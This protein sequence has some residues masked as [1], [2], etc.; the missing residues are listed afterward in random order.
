MVHDRRILLFITLLCSV[1]H[2]T[3]FSEG[4]VASTY[5]VSPNPAIYQNKTCHTFSYYLT[6]VTKYFTWSTTLLFLPGTHNIIFTAGKMVVIKDVG[7]VNFVGVKLHSNDNVSINCNRNIYAGITFTNITTVNIVNLTISNCGA[8]VSEFEGCTTRYDFVCIAALVA[9]NVGSFLVQ[10]TVVENSTKIGIFGYIVAHLSITKSKFVGNSL[11]EK[12]RGVTTSHCN[13]VISFTRFFTSGHGFEVE[14][15]TVSVVNSW[16]VGNYDGINVKNS[17]ASFRGL[18]MLGPEYDDRDMFAS[19]IR[20]TNST[21]AVYGSSFSGYAACITASTCITNVSLC[22][23]ENNSD[24]LVTYVGSQTRVT[25]SIFVQNSGFSQFHQDSSAI[26]KNTTYYNNRRSCIFAYNSTIEFNGQSLFQNCMSVGFGGA[27]YLISSIMLLTAPANVSFVN[28]TAY[29]GGGAIY[30]QSPFIRSFEQCF[31]QIIDEHGT[32]NNPGVRLYFEGNKAWKVGSVL[33]G[34]I[35]SCHLDYYKVDDHPLTIFAAISTID[36]NIS[37]IASDAFTMC[38]CKDNTASPDCNLNQSYSG[39]PGQTISIVGLDLYGSISPSMV[40]SYTV[41]FDSSAAMLLSLQ[42]N[43][44]ACY[45]YVVQSNLDDKTLCMLT[46]SAISQSKILQPLCIHFKVFECP[47]G[48]VLNDTS[49]TC[50]CNQ[51]LLGANLSCSIN[52]LTVLKSGRQWVGSISNIL[53]AYDSCPYDYCIPSPISMSLNAPDDQC[54]YYRG[55]ILCGY[56]L[57]GL[58]AMFGSSRCSKCSNYYTSF[59]SRRL[60]CWEWH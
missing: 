23:F 34:N 31:L 32:L 21:L 41:D 18:I 49:K 6:A 58:S 50:S 42:C 48:F 47:L 24:V 45:D 51:F 20:C 27:I 9:S 44:N 57:E 25:D 46:Q 1:G 2:Q 19:G 16:V 13:L 4:Q 59:I 8:Q 39:Y 12:C 43:Q 37:A 38:V 28:N 22:N 17:N 35:K 53:V 52:N 60:R 40:V 36:N 7:A 11:S 3:I 26:L 33:Y 30:A 56:C 5:C 54:N 55:G 15:S 10:D 14:N 29:I